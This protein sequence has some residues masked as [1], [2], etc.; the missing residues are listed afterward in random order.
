[1]QDLKSELQHC[2]GSENFYKKGMLGMI[3]TDGVETIAERAECNW[4]ISDIEV[5]ALMKLKK[6]EFL[7]IKVKVK[8]SKVRVIYEDGNDNK[9]FTQKYKYTDLPD[10]EL[11]FFCANKTLMIPQEY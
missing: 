11:E 7:S 5:I 1:M 8:D 9:L 2:I 4:L 3:T 6:H 10:C